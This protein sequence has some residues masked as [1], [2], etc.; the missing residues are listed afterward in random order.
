MYFKDGRAPAVPE[1]EEAALHFWKDCARNGS[2]TSKWIALET[3]EDAIK[4]REK[5]QQPPGSP[6][7]GRTTLDQ[8]GLQ[9]RTHLAICTLSEAQDLPAET[10]HPV[11]YLERLVVWQKAIGRLLIFNLTDCQNIAIHVPSNELNNV[12]CFIFPAF[13]SIVIP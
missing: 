1:D 2:K 8:V 10:N 3:F 4:T 13:A 12:T 6:S 7:A 5:R 9:Q 11:P